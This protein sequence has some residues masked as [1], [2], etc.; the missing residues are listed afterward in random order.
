MSMIK[1]RPSMRSGIALGL[2]TVVV[3]SATA[4]SARQAK[5][6]APAKGAMAA[7]TNDAEYTKRIL[8]NTPDKRILTEMVDHLP[9]SAT[10][11]T[12]LKVLGYIAGENGN[13]TYSADIYKY[14]DALDA[15]SARVTC[16]S[17][18]K[19]E[20]GR[21]TRACA[22]ADEL[23]IKS[24][25]K[26]KQMTAQLTDPRKLTD[27]QAKQLIGTAKPIYWLIISL[28][29]TKALVCRLQPHKYYF[30]NL[31]TLE[32]PNSLA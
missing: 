5:P 1:N 4:L 15:A 25:D 19:T 22:V 11:P 24:L 23:T 28:S 29:L 20:E 21:D 17:I 3:V 14:L 31:E 13:L 18:G 30:R 10:V 6:A 9:A 2:M 7:Q 12:M 32:L 16:W 8:D 26:Y 27:A